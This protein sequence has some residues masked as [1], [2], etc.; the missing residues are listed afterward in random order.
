MSNKG[1]V[2]MHTLLS[3]TVAD[4]RNTVNAYCLVLLYFAIMDLK[5]LMFLTSK[6]ASV[7]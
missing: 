2:L 6:L 4:F 3:I 1:L 7:H 5:V